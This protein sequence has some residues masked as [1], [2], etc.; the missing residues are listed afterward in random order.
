MLL[1]KALPKGVGE[2][3]EFQTKFKRQMESQE[4]MI[5]QFKL[6]YIIR[7]ADKV[8]KITPFHNTKYFHITGLPASWKIL[9]SPGI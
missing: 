3:V 7:C 4:K 8:S 1:G 9:E 6:K 5:G 2:G